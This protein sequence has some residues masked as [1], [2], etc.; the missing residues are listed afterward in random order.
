[1]KK[2]SSQLVCTHAPRNPA[3]AVPLTGLHAAF[4][5][6]FRLSDRK[7]PPRTRLSLS[8]QPEKPRRPH[9]GGSLL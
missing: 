9:L 8:R 2:R 7:A 6:L 5:G 4:R 3:P 1:M